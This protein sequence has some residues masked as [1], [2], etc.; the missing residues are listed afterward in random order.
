[1]FC[2]ED[3]NTWFWCISLTD[4]KQSFQMLIAHFEITGPFFECKAGQGDLVTFFA[5]WI[6]LQI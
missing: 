5:T 2:S 1:M 4:E 6:I 3:A